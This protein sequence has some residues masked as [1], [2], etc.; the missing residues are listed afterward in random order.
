MVK[1]KLAEIFN[2]FDPIEL[3]NF[4][5][6]SFLHDEASI[7]NGI[8]MN[9]AINPLQPTARFEIAIIGVN[10]YINSDRML[11]V[12]TP[13]IIREEL[14]RLK[15][16]SSGLRIAD[17]GNLK[18]GININETLF[19]LQEA[20]ALLFHIKVNVVI[21]GGSQLLTVGNFRAFKEFENNINLV[22]IDS[23]IDLASSPGSMNECNYLNMII[24]QEASHL[25]N[26]A[27]VGYQSY[28]VDPK[29]I[30]RLN[31]HYFEHYRLGVVRNQFE[32]IEPILRDA[33]L[34]SLDISALRMSDAP[35][36][37]DGSP[38][39]F[40]ADE[41]C[42]LSRYAGLSDRVQSFGV[43]EV[44]AKLDNARQ[45]SKLVAQIIWYY[46]EG[47]VNRKHDFPKALLTDYTKYEV[48]IDEI[49]FPI[50]FYKSNKSNRWWIE[51]QGSSNIEGKKETMVV[52]CAESDYQSACMNEIPDRWW[53]NFKKL[54]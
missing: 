29:Q 14:Y 44:D 32:H 33:D 5:N 36:Q 12:N 45:T 51:V 53:V 39:G 47:Y 49:D 50:V 31:E 41:V 7:G 2:F 28:F 52:A 46:F 26:L 22:H 3:K 30:K 42:R 27:C 4:E 34:V 25:Y 17:L 48:Q 21:I 10:H 43:F 9:S 16:V 23:K 15:K 20:C 1:E 24:E 35:A 38:N 19:A 13:Q 18:T 40:Y 6:S 11:S 8:L 37:T 54:K